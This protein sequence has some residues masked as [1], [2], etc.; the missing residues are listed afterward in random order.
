MK[1][2]FEKVKRIPWWGYALGAGF[3]ILQRIFYRLAEWLSQILGTVNYAFECRIPFLDDPIKLIPAFVVIYI[4]SFVFWLCGPV[5][6]SLTKKKN[7]VN[8]IAGML[9]AYFIGFLFFVF[10]P[11]YMDRAAEG[12]TAGAEGPGIF[13]WLLRWIYSA[14]G[15]DKAFNLFPSYH[16]LISLYCYFGVRK[17]PEISKEYQMYSLILTGLI[18][19][20]T[21]FTKQHYIVDVFGGLAI[22]LLVYIVVEKWNPGK[23]YEKIQE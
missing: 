19:L 18:C 11:T 10:M 5:A 13:K 4:Y 21:L 20:S 15:G 7:V 16:C 12:L 3:F 6:V 23:K 14:D 9:I 8:F 2:F 1:Q 17:Q 22:S